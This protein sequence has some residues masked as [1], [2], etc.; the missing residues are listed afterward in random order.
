MQIKA[1]FPLADIEAYLEYEYEVS[2]DKLV[3]RQECIP[4]YVPLNSEFQRVTRY[5]AVWKFEKLDDNTTELLYIV[6]LGGP[7][8]LP[9]F[10]I[11]TF[12][13]TGPIETLLNLNELSVQ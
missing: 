10:L 12:L 3:M 11:K 6:K 7:Q 5:N 2:E 8:N 4:Y 1:P 9:K 13:C